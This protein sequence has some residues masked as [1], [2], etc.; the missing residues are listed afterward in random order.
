MLSAILGEDATLAPLKRRIIETT[1]AIPFFMEETIQALIDEGS[2]QRTE[3]GLKLVRPLASLRIPA[4]VQAIL[5]ARI[6]R[7]QNDEK[8][9]L[10]TFSVL[11]REFVLSLARAVAGKSEYDFERLIDRKSTRLNSS[12]LGISYAVFCFKKKK[13]RSR[14]SWFITELSMDHLARIP[15]GNT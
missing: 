11:G 8:N 14:P 5:A 3:T 7:L 4:T 6:D 2:L 15:N 12:H 1:G 13:L 10:Q 9:L